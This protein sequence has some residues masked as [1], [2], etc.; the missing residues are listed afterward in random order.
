MGPVHGLHV[1]LLVVLPEVK[2]CVVFQVLDFI[3]FRKKSLCWR[4]QRFGSLL[5]LSTSHESS[6]AVD[7]LAAL[8]LRLRDTEGGLRLHLPIV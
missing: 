1:P 6:P 5:S 2:I 7:I 4:L 3:L 8:R